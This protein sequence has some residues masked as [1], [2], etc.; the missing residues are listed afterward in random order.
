MSKRQKS[1]LEKFLSLN[2]H[3]RRLGGKKA[4]QNLASID[5][6]ALKNK[7]I[8]GEITQYTHGSHKD[9]EQQFEYLKGEFA[10]QSELLYFHAKLIVLLRRSISIETNFSNFQQL[11]Q[12]ES[13]YLLQHLNLRWLVSA[14]ETFVDYSDDPI[15]KALALNV[16]CLVN[17]V[18][19]TESERFL[20]GLEESKDIPERQGKLDDGRVALFDGLSAFKAGTDDTLRNMRWRIDR[21]AALDSTGPTGEI[22]QTCFS[23]LQEQPN[24]FERFRKRHTRQKTQWWDS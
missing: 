5:Y 24:C 18:K 4:T 20:Q 16:S 13:D 6:E 15:Q 12:Q 11:W 8:D 23:R 2:Q 3:L 17:T 21:I 10:G 7:T 22:L 19:I 14:A 1:K 9:L